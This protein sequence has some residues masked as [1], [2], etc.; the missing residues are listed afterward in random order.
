VIQSDASGIGNLCTGESSVDLPLFSRTHLTGNAASP[1]PKCINGTCNA[2]PKVGMACIPVGT[3]QT[4]HDCPPAPAGLLPPF[5]VDLNPLSTAPVSKTAADG[6]FCPGQSN[7][8]PGLSGAFG[9]GE[10][11]CIQENGT[12]AG[13]LTDGLV[14][15]GAIL[16]SVFCIP[17]VPGAG[18][19]TINAAADL[20]GPGG[21][22]LPVTTQALP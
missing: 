22:T 5:A 15:T 2:G 20:P 18:G 1:C 8:T 21:I 11:E 17:A 16:G 9:F 6:N 4:T 12:S 3:L 10:A 14:H 7:A 19:V 13:D